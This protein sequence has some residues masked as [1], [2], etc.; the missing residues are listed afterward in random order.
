MCVHFYS[1]ADAESLSVLVSSRDLFHRLCTSLADLLCFNTTLVELC[2]DPPQL[3]ALSSSSSVRA[4]H[5]IRTV[6]LFTKSFTAFRDPKS[7]QLIQAIAA[8]IA[9]QEN[10]VDLFL[11]TC[12]DVMNLQTGGS[13]RNSCILLTTAGLSGYLANG[14]S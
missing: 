5:K 3:D 10:T 9:G 4:I 7:L 12:R 11:D 1:F 6:H 13:L 2:N 14:K 8:R